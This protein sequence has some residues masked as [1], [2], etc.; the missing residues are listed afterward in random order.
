[1]LQVVN[2]TAPEINPVLDT[3]RLVLRTL[4]VLAVFLALSLLL[5]RLD[6]PVEERATAILQRGGY[7]GAFLFV[8][9]VDTF[10]VPASL[11]VLFPLTRD[12]NPL[13]LLLTLSTASVSGGAFGYW[14][15]RALHHLPFVRRT[16]AGYWERGAPLV[17]RLGY[18]A[19]VLA[20]LTPIPF[21]TVSWIAGMLRLPFPRYLRGA[22]WRVPRVVGW[23]ALL[24][25]G[26]RFSGGG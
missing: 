23:W 25:A 3:R 16:V 11:D 13:P 7:P 15:G 22:L 6:L 26:L 19:V 20:A 5:V 14:I 8:L 4:L 9:L 2:G 24:Q 17:E 10:I 18:R 21:S 1:M 12:W